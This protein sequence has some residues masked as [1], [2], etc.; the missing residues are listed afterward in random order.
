MQ[1]IIEIEERDNRLYLSSEYEPIVCGNTNYYLKFSFDEDWSKCVSK[2]AFFVIEGKKIPVLFEGDICNIPAMPN[3]NSFLVFLVAAPSEGEI[4][5]ST[6]IKLNLERNPSMDKLK[7]TEPFK[8]YYSALLGAINKVE[9]GKIK[10]AEVELAKRAEIADVSSSQVSKTGDEEISGVKNF[11]DGLKID[12]RDAVSEKEISNPNILIN[13]DFKV[14]QREENSLSCTRNYFVDRWYFIGDEEGMSCNLNDD[15]S[16]SLTNNNET[17]SMYFFQSIEFPENYKNQIFTMSVNVLNYSGLPKFYIY[18]G[19]IKGEDI[20]KTGISSITYSTDEEIQVFRASFCVP[21]N[22]SLTIRYVKLEQGNKLTNFVEKS[23]SAELLDCQR[24]YLNIKSVKNS[25]LGVGILTEKTN[26]YYK[27]ELLLNVPN[28]MRIKPE[29]KFKDLKVTNS[30]YWHAIN[31]ISII[32]TISTGI[33]LQVYTE[34][35]DSLSN[36]QV[37]LLYMSGALSYLEFDAEI[38]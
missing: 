36:G 1:N 4:L 24:F 26:S 11:V 33:S 29:V 14:N 21:A 5:S 6:P 31:N 28:R 32:D 13:G 17:G 35:K 10:I 9:S 16:I 18:D 7:K 3:L 20:D 22:S 30:N 23:Y 34:V 27:Y 19:T 25:K 2:T 8:S 38:Y 12:G 37:A 15:G